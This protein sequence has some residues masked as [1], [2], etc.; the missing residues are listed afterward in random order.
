MP[1]TDFVK[2]AQFSTQVQWAIEAHGD[3]F[4]RRLRELVEI[5]QVNRE[6]SIR[7]ISEAFIAGDFPSKAPL[8]LE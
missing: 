5:H 2:M 6:V 8:T 7:Y 3:V 4:T 1:V